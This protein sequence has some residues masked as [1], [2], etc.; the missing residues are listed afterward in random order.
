MLCRDKLRQQPVDALVRKMGEVNAT[1]N[2]T[3]GLP[4]GRV[5]RHAVT[6]QP[7]I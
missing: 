6:Q 7:R 4:N 5:D 2:L 1:R 3:N